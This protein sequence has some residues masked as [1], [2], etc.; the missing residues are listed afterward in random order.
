MHRKEIFREIV[1]L[2]LGA[3]MVFGVVSLITFQPADISE[4]YCP[5]NDPVENSGGLVGARM[6]Y[7]L[8][9]LFGRLAGWA[10]VL[11]VGVWGFVLLFRRKLPAL[12]YKIGGGVLFLVALS[13]AESLS[14]GAGP[15][16]LPAGGLAGTLLTEGVLLVNIGKM[17]TVLLVVYVATIS[18]LMATDFLFYEAVM[19]SVGFFRNFDIRR[20]GRALPFV[21]R[22]APAPSPEPLDPEYAQRLRLDAE[23]EMEAIED[24][25]A[26]RRERKLRHGRMWNLMNQTTA[27]METAG[28]MEGG[29]PG[30]GGAVVAVDEDVEP[31]LEDLEGVLEVEEE[32]ANVEEPEPLPPTPEPVE[33]EEEEPDEDGEEAAEAAAP[34]GH[35]SA[36]DF[37]LPGVDLLVPPMQATEVDAFANQR[38]AQILEGTLACFKIDTHVVGIIQ[39]PTITQFE[40]QL[41]PGTRVSS[42]VNLSNELAIALRAESVRVVPHIPG[43][44]TIGV[45]VPN[46]K[47]GIVRLR[48]LMESEE[49][50]ER[51]FKLPLFMGKD[52]AGRC[53]VADLVAMPHILIA[54]STGS[55]KSICINS[56]VASL[57][58]TQT[59]S[60]VKFIL[61]D[62]KRVEMVP[63]QGIP[64]LMTPVVT[65]MKKAAVALE[66]L[67]TIMDE[68]YALFEKAGVRQISGYNRLRKEEV[69]G[70]LSDAGLDPD[71]V[72]YPLPYI[73]VIVDEL[74]DLM[75]VSSKEVEQSIIRLAQKSRAVGIHLILSTQR[76]S[77]DVITGLIKSNMPSRIAFRVTS[78]VES[79]VILDGQGAE[80]LLGKG[81]MLYQPPGGPN[82]IRCQGTL[83]DD[84]EIAGI[85]EHLKRAAPPV[86]SE[87]IVQ[88]DGGLADSPGEEDTLFRDAGD[89]ILKTGRASTTLLQRQFAIGYTRASRIIDQLEK[90]GL[91]GRF[92]GSKSRKIEMTFEEWEA[93]K[94]G[95]AGD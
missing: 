17:G 60:Q 18:F 41:K 15:S 67:T 46:H 85:T 92:Q 70:R 93:Y 28:S 84:E 72:E 19:E 34:P 3:F 43:K 65:N 20:L 82:L 88:V 23:S 78:G 57:L 90:V 48:E 40:L 12:G 22:P 30:A 52:A 25:S 69:V 16:V 79:R 68:R 4:L 32:P 66:N 89:L 2:A 55:G 64:H 6:A 77:S 44:G 37:E 74:S 24:T 58:L 36:G 42:V 54:G 38:R 87:Q 39:G 86:Y 83:V 13:V 95:K 59:P 91:V 73:V 56:L 31:A 5:C 63:F 50:G 53:I 75:L 33:A 49:Y 71:A 8:F 51:N 14:S 35:P 27:I 47:K 7:H 9:Y 1:G 26:R 81:D 80:K 61:I 94:E 10:L 76:P 21:P 62:P 11:L 45:E 29:A